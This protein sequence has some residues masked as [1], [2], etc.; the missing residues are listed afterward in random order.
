MK[1]LCTQAIQVGFALSLLSFGPFLNAAMAQGTSCA[2]QLEH[3]QEVQNAIKSLGNDRASD[4][5]RPMLAGELGRSVNQFANCITPVS[6]AP[7]S[8]FCAVERR[9]Q[10]DAEAAYDSDGSDDPAYYNDRDQKLDEDRIAAFSDYFS[11]LQKSA[12]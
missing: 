1:K 6:P 10:L 8:D 4:Y 12:K 7:A 2:G 9:H 5:S 11:C 3:I